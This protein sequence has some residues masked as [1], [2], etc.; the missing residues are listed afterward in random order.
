M[1]TLFGK[2]FKS[3]ALSAAL[4][5][6]LSA[7][8]DAT[9]LTWDLSNVFFDDGTQATGSITFFSLD[10]LEPAAWDVTVAPF[11]E[12]FPF[13]FTPADSDFTFTS[14]ANLEDPQI[15]LIWNVFNNTFEIVL[16]EFTL[17]ATGTVDLATR[18]SPFIDA[19]GFHYTSLEQVDPN[20]NFSFQRLVVSGSLVAESTGAPEPSTWILA[21]GV[22][23]TLAGWKRKRGSVAPKVLRP[24]SRRGLVA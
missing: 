11:G 21:G 7:R 14:A 5:M 20:V 12:F 17:P 6:L 16:A 10:S 24:T 13:T 18:S 22:L 1:T 4:V 3:L 2:V 19:T 8:A 15:D 23:L 9:S